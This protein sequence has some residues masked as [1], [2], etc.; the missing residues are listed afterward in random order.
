[1]MTV[2]SHH[3]RLQN[4][5]DNISIQFGMAVCGAVFVH[6]NILGKPICLYQRICCQAQAASFA[7]Q[8]ILAMTW[9]CLCLHEPEVVACRHSTGQTATNAKDTAMSMRSRRQNS[10]ARKTKSVGKRSVAL[11]H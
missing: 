8:F 4:V 2:M 9:G 11:H 10:K 3:T 1:M 5:K 6:G 7:S